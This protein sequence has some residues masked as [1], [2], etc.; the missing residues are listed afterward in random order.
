MSA[1]NVESTSFLRRLTKVAAI[2][3]LAALGCGSLLVLRRELAAVD[4]RTAAGSMRQ[5]S[6]T[7]GSELVRIDPATN[8][9]VGRIPLPGANTVATGLGSVWV[10]GTVA[11]KRAVIRISPVTTEVQAEVALEPFRVVV[12]ADLAVGAGAVWML[13]GEAVYRL[14]GASGELTRIPMRA[15]DV[16][17]TAIAAGDEGVWVSNPGKGAV[18]RIHPPAR[19]G[20]RTIALGRSA[21]GLSLA[22]GSIWVTS[23]GE[24]LL[25]RIDPAQHRVTRIYQVPGASGSAAVG[26]GAVWVVNS[27]TGMLAKLDPGSGRVTAVDLGRRAT[28]VSTGQGSIWVVHGGDGMVSRVDPATLRVTATIPVGTRPYALAVDEA[29]VW[30][31]VLGPVGHPH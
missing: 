7:A 19:P 3:M 22:G 9:V 6:T 31:T 29:A 15:A 1:G 13:G 27:V 26:G 4:G 5:A 18:E 16:A 17:R 8:R 24:G 21:G 25:T 11:N 2:V 12:A 20:V 10:T 23:D 14:D 30:V 28:W